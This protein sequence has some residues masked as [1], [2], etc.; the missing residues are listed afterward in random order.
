M[1]G[2][3]LSP[4]EMPRKHL[5][6]KLKVPMANQSQQIH[7]VSGKG[8]V[9]K[10]L[11][12]VC[13]ARAFAHAGR[14]TLLGE[15]GDRS[16]F[17]DFLHL[18]HVG[19]DPVETP[20]G[21]EVSQWTAQEA[22]R[23]YALHLIKV[24]SLYRLLFDNRV[25]RSLINIAPGLTELAVLGKITSGPRH[26]GP[27]VKAERVVVDAASTGHFLAMLRA[28]G[29]MAS[30]IRFGPM[31]EQSRSMDNTLRD[32]QICHYWL[33]CL[34]EDGPVKETEEL[35]AQ[36]KEEFGI[37]ARI[38]LNKVLPFEDVSPE[39]LEGDA[40]FLKF[41]RAA[42]ARQLEARERLRKLDRELIEVPLLL[43]HETSDLFNEAF[44]RIRL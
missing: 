33:V 9:G 1:N 20:F 27:P 23:E 26:H 12:A 24:E 30:A 43:K 41:A 22:L 15:L 3:D 14:R 40:P 34:P 13:L 37:D 8:G 19:Y 44:E 10:S 38:V 18:P 2:K 16:Y 7:F 36:L 5:Q 39:I 32:P 4:C 42:Q 35:Y 17:K 31:G 6:R 21:F 25:S 28:P 29:G 11:W